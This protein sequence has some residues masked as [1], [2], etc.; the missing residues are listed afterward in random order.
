M[1]KKILLT[2]L[3]LA[4][5][6]VAGIY[7][8]RNTLVEKAVESGSEYALGVSTNL[9]S[10]SLSIGGGSLSLDDFSVSNPEGFASESFF[11]IESGHL[12]VDAG[13]LLDDEVRVDSLVLN[14]MQ[15]R[16]EQIDTKSNFKAIL[17]HVRSIDLG[18]SESGS[19]KFRID[20][21]VLRDVEVSAELTA[22]GQR[23]VS[24]TFTLDEIELNDV[25]RDNGAS[26]GQIT[27]R[28]VDAVITTAARESKGRLPGQIADQLKSA[29]GQKVQEKLEDV[30]ADVADKVKDLGG[31]LLNSGD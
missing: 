29:A 31:S 11:R 10:A 3:I 18:S 13:S 20:R 21:I 25:G 2:I 19:Q 9:G 1:L 26:I 14:G 23:Q 28:I 15:L 22:M 24:E 8:I 30:G 6:A 16:L 17:D 5:V 7:I 27:G 4:V 12:D